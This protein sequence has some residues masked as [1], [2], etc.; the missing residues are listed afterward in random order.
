MHVKHIDSSHA[1]FRHLTSSLDLRHDSKGRDANLYLKLRTD[2]GMITE[3]PAVFFSRRPDVTPQTVL[4][5]FFHVLRPFVMMVDQIYSALALLGKRGSGGKDFSIRYNSEESS[6]AFD[7]DA[8]RR[9]QKSYQEI[10][11]RNW[12]VKYHSDAVPGFHYGPERLTRSD[13]SGPS[14]G[15]ASITSAQLAD[16]LTTLRDVA[17]AHVRTLQTLVADWETEQFEITPEVFVRYGVAPS[18]GLSFVAT[19]SAVRAWLDAAQWAVDHIPQIDI[20]SV[21][22]LRS[23]NVEQNLRQLEWLV[24]S[25]GEKRDE[26]KIIESLLEFL[27]LPY[28]KKRWQVFEIWILALCLRVM[29]EKR[30]VVMTDDGPIVMKTGQ[31]KAPVAAARIGSE[32][33]LEL[34]LEYPLSDDLR[35]DIAFVRQDRSLKKPISVIEC[36]QRESESDQVLIGDAQ[37]YAHLM[38]AGSVNLLV[39]YDK[40]TGPTLHNGISYQDGSVETIFL[41]SVQPNTK[42]A[43]RISEF[44][45]KLL[46]SVLREMAF[47]VDTT[48]SMHAHLLDVW[49]TIEDLARLVSGAS[50]P[51]Y[52]G[53]LFGDHGSSEPY[54][55]KFFPARTKIV[56]LVDSMRSAP[57]SSGGDTPEAL[58]DALHVVNS[59]AESFGA[60]RLITVFTDAPAHNPNECPFGFDFADETS[61]LLSNSYLVVVNCGDSSWDQL[62]WRR[63]ENSPLCAL[64]LLPQ[65][66]RSEGVLSLIRKASG[67]LATSQKA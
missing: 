38:P 57:V 14:G 21:L 59:A 23:G 53:I 6:L 56:D 18:D 65:A 25:L 17:M 12:L 31:S 11:V 32:S 48:G 1:L 51:L 42:E 36:K 16:A 2:L 26:T 54:V 55:T 49:R 10:R 8:F 19:I 30:A 64:T 45:T 44:V 63:F 41:D 24:N 20:T 13:L 22:R 46:P 27:E 50:Q 52:S 61:R 9:F 60:V 34:W 62:G 40:F 37:K 3:K 67:S 47:I 33:L 4:D 43:S 29:A 28:W 58:E 66:T 5:T 39:N 15:S 7:L 35:P